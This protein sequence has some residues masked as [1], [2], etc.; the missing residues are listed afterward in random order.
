MSGHFY[1]VFG[2]GRQGTA[3]VHDLVLYC[4][5]HRLL[6]IE[7]DAARRKA[8]AARL[9]RLLGR[10]SA[11]IE[12]RG[13]ASRADLRGCDAILSCAPYAANPALTKLAL[14]A[15]VAFL[16]L[17]GN[18]E[19]VREQERL[20][21]R[22]STPVIPDCGVSPGLTNILAVHCARVHAC[23][24]IEVRCGGLPLVRPDP[25][26]NPLQYKLVFSARGLL[27][28]YSGPV[29]VIRA[30]KLATVPALS[31]IEELDAAHESSPTSNNSPQ[32][33]EYLRECGVR[34]YNYMTVRYK[35]H[36]QLVQGWKALGWL[37][38]DDE[39]DD[40][41]ARKLEED[42][43]LRYSPAKDRDKLMLRVRGS[44]TRSAM[45]RGFEY[46]FVAVADRRTRFSAM[47]LT[48]SWGITIVAHH[49][50]SGRG[51]PKGFATPERFVDTEWTIAELEKRLSTIRLRPGA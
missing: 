35:G 38:G 37:Q 22:A 28:E 25:A 12:Y 14:S 41:L 40:E 32:V 21:K 42:P 10:K 33:V 19:V 31:L 8:A 17:G 4:G 44:N 47:E 2:A 5:A 45:Q 9:N 46:S 7:P 20:A 49:V 27:S 18:P 43:V 11:I 26:L 29:P 6:V 15:G 13:T 3:A 50:A 39:R 30:G 1:A 23:D 51:A 16:D 36:W 48:T 34:D 24:R